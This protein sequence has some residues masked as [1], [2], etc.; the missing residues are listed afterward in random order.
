VNEQLDAVAQL[1]EHFG[2]A[3]TTALFL[4]LERARIYIAQQR[5]EDAER[6]LLLVRD[7]QSSATGYPR[8]GAV[9]ELAKVWR[10]LG[11]ARE[12]KAALGE[13][14]D[15]IESQKDSRVVVMTALVGI[16]EALLESG[17]QERARYES[18]W[19]DVTG[20]GYEAQAARELIGS[21][22]Y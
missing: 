9:R 19:R 1:R 20:Q 17:E 22:I 8:L 2:V 11:R 14:L 16:G 12:A 7:A 6:D 4:L 3:Q 13:I 5:W 15:V 10:S 21:W 18:V